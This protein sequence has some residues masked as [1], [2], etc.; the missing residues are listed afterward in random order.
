MPV[1]ERR[2]GFE[3]LALGLVGVRGELTL[4]LGRRAFPSRQQRPD[5]GLGIIG[6][7]DLHT[8]PGQVSLAHGLAD[9]PVVQPLA[10]ARQV[11]PRSPRQPFRERHRHA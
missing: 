6:N 1:G 5:H 4:E 10:I 2:D 8:R 7:L 11:Q 9:G 3:D